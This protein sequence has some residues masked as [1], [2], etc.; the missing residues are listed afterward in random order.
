LYPQVRFHTNVGDIDVALTPDV[1]PLTVANFMSYV[2]KGAY[3]N[4]IF[5]RSLPGFIIQ[6]GGFQLINHTRTAYTA[7]AAIKNEFNVTNAR[8]TIAMAKLDGNPNSATNQW[9]FNLNNNGSNLDNQNGGF[10][11]FGK[12]LNSAGLAVIDKM[13]GFPTFNLDGNNF[14]ATPL[15]NYKSGTI[16]DA[17]YV[18]VTSI[19]TIP[20]TIPSAFTDAA[21]SVGTST[22]GIAP[23]QILAI[24][25]KNIGPTALTSSAADSTGLLPN[26][27]AGTRVLFNNNPVPILF[28]SSEQINVVAPYS[29]TGLNTVAVVVEYQG[30]RTGTISMPVAPANPSIFTSNYGKGDAVIQRFPDYTLINSSNPAQPGDILILYA[31]GQ[32]AVSPT[33]PDGSIVGATVPLPV[34]QPKLL[35]DGQPV[36]LSYAGS[37]PG[38][39]QGALQVNFTVPQLAPGTHQ[40]QLQVGDRTSPTGVT[41]ATK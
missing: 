27:V 3:V 13:A 16:Q 7:D 2:N 41:L 1:A 35:I 19:V 14:A 17:N 33:L 5:H 39:V 38:L 30:I 23:G 21:S 10:T 6:A 8:G 34:V 4:S 37:A 26:S 36:P 28:T 40:I 29:L 20:N 15:Q 22:T 24:Y 12:I 32:G 11:V 18:L 25:G 31:E 9:F